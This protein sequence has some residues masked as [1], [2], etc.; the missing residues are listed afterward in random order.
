MRRPIERTGEGIGKQ[1]RPIALDHRRRGRDRLF[2]IGS[3]DIS[4]A[5]GFR[6]EPRA[7]G[8][9]TRLHAVIERDDIDAIAFA[10]Y[11]DAARLII[12]LRGR[13]RTVFADKPPRRGGAAHRAEH[14]N[15]QHRVGGA[16]RRRADLREAEANRAIALRTRPFRQSD[17][18]EQ[19]AFFVATRVGQIAER[20]AQTQ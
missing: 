18:V 3:D 6:Q 4:N 12:H 15:P 1:H 7:L 17:Q 14:A 20:R 10:A 13:L 11:F 9:A 19:L 5:L 2:H 8:G 16:N